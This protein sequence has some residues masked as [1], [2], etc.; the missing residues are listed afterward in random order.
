MS[1]VP[2]PDALPAGKLPARDLAA[3][4]G[5]IAPR[6][7]RLL[8][9]PAP[10]E[11]AAV[12][13]LGDRRLIVAA[14][15]ITFATDRVGWYAVHVNANDVAV[16]GARPCWFVAVLLMPEGCARVAVQRVMD[17][18]HATCNEL[19]VA[20]AGGHTEITAG[21]TRPI[22]VG[23]MI[24]EAAPDALVMKAGLQVGDAI[25]LTQGAAIEG[26]ALLARELPSRL[27]PVIGEDRLESAR[28][29][30][31]QPGISVVSAARLA[32]STCRV[33]SMHDPTEG[34]VLSGL[35]EMASAAR[36]G[37]RTRASTIPVLDETRAICEAL[38]A[39]PLW[40]IASGALLV[41][42]APDEAETLVGAYHD[43][44]IP[45]A[46]VA[47]AVPAAD[48]I[49]VERDG[50]WMPLLPAPRDEV[51]RILSEG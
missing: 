34:G 41:A 27:A 50:R 1:G 15:P 38:G 16:M 37:L 20:V 39:D 10:G 12:V 17:D 22:V 6:D 30:L 3:M 18:I 11:D 36:L 21:I 4:L 40:L 49:Q 9:G 29:L 31:F 25:V 33:H 8:V 26:T 44:G 51:A 14:D 42:A 32:S 28:R 2:D 43:A 24:G 48:G 35:H 7:P 47:E 5:R 45:A 46:I 19:G 23:Q 13:A